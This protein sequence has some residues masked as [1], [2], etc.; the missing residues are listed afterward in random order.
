MDIT[1]IIKALNEESNIAACIDSCMREANAYASEIILVDSLSTD[2][3]V[4]IA[5]QYPIDIVQFSNQNDVGCGAAAQLGFQCSKGKYIFLI[6]AD[7]ELIEGFV[8]KALDYLENNTD[9]AGVSGMI[10]DN[11][12]L[13]SAD[14]RRINRYSNT[15]GVTSVISLGGGGL[16]RREAIEKSSYFAHPKLKACEELELGVRLKSIDYKLIRLGTPSVTHTGHHETEGQM[17]LRLWGNGRLSAYTTFLK[18]TLF[19]SWFWISIRE[20]W[21]VFVAPVSLI[22]FSSLLLLG[23]SFNSAFVLFLA[24]WLGI[25]SLLSI[26]KKSFLSAFWSIAAWWLFFAASYKGIVAKLGEPDLKL[27]FRVLAV[28]TRK[29]VIY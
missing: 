2:K 9:T 27:R 26:K 24:S 5:K 1:F 20:C 29:S 25:F 10:I 4:E 16:Y 3:T 28:A 21:F 19:R 17:L 8:A 18:S 15:S 14:K 13:T 12:V 7:M 11:Q 22:L 23:I 6:D